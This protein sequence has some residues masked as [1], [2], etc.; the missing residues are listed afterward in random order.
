MNKSLTVIYAFP[1]YVLPRGLGFNPLFLVHNL[2]IKGCVGEGHT[3]C[4]HREFEFQEMAAARLLEA[5]KCHAAWISARE[6]TDSAA[7]I[8]G[9]KTCP[10]RALSNYRLLGFHCSLEQPL[11]HPHVAWLLGRGRIVYVHSIV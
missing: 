2:M 8:N 6:K 5:G 9:R 1:P 3:L 4:R 7:T 11:T 10:T